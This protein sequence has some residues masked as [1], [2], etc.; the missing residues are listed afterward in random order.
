MLV[1]LV[2]TPDG[3]GSGYETGYYSVTVLYTSCEIFTV[4][5]V[6]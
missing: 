3:K 5:M 1:S 4:C 6:R 2:S